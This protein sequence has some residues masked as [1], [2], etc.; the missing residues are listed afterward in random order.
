MIEN[1]IKFKEVDKT[2]QD[3]IKMSSFFAKL[4]GNDAEY[5]AKLEKRYEENEDSFEDVVVLC[6]YQWFLA[7]DTLDLEDTNS[8]F[9]VTFNVL[10]IIDCT[11][12]KHPEYWILWL[13][14]YKI[15]SFTNFDDDDFINQLK[16]FIGQQKHNEKRTYFLVSQILLAHVYYIKDKE[17]EAIEVLD[18]ILEEYD[19]KISYL[20]QFFKG[21]VI[22]F[23]N[24]VKRS[25]DKEILARLDAIKEKYWETNSKKTVMKGQE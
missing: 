18:N 16:W 3:L 2:T 13:L 23:E 11:V 19:G 5:I 15:I 1:S 9:Q 20:Q 22:E 12:D 25:G 10:N 4:K 24:V 8:V 21:F 14:K 7:D 6:F 17:K